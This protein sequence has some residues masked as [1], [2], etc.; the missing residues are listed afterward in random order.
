MWLTRV[1]IERPTLGFVLVALTLIAGFMALRNL[2][3]QEQPNSGLPAITVSA[4]YSGAS[5][6][7]LQTEIA[8]PIEDQLAGTPYLQNIQTTIQ[9]GQ[10]S[11][12]ATFSLQS[13]DTENI[14]NVE[15]A[16]QAAQK[17][18]PNTVI[19]TLRVADPSQPTIVTLAL[20]SK[21]Y[22]TG[23]LSA[24]ANNQIVPVI[25]QLPG[26]SNVNVAGTTQPAFMV[27]VNPGLL[28]ADNL[29]LT[30]V[31]NAITPN[32]LRAPG[33]YVYGPDRETELDVRGDLPDPQSVANL[34]I[35]V[36]YSGTTTSTSTTSTGGAG[37]GTSGSSG[38]GGSSGGG[39]NTVGAGSAGASSGTGTSSTGG[40]AQSSG[41]A[42]ASGGSTN[43]NPAVPRANATVLPL[44]IG[45]FVASTASTPPNATAPPGP[46]AGSYGTSTGGSGTTSAA[47]TSAGT[48]GGSSA[49]GSSGGSGGTATSGESASTTGKATTAQSS[50]GTG[51][52]SGASTSGATLGG[53]SG[54]SQSAGSPTSATSSQSTGSSTTNQSSSANVSVDQALAP[55][56]LT[57]TT[58]SSSGTAS[59]SAQPAGGSNPY[60]SGSGISSSPF[61]GALE[62]WAVPSADKRISDVATVLNTTV[63][64]RVIS[65]QNGR[66]GLTLLIQKQATASEVTVSN[67]VIAALPALERT[68][69]GVQFQV[70]HVQST[71]TEEQVESVEHTLV[72]GIVLTAIVML[73]FLGSWR[74]AVV[75][76]IAIPTSLGVTLFAM[77]MM[78]L[79]LDTISLMAMT[80]VIGILIDDS[81]VVLEN[82]QR[83]YDAGEAP[84]DAALNGRSEIGL[85]AIVITMVDVVVFLPIAF[86]GG[87]VGQNLHEFAIV[88][89]VATLTSLFV[90]FTI[91][92]MMAGLW[93]LESTW[94]PWR[95]IR[96][97]D[98]RFNNVRSR[99]AE[100]WL[101]AALGNPWPVLIA[102]VVLCVLAYLLVPTGLVGEEY[103]PAEDQGII[104]A[105]VTYPPGHPLS[106]T[107]AAMS[108][109]E[110]ATKAVI[111]PADL[112]YEVTIAGA[113]S[114]AFGGFVQE[115]N[116]GQVSIYLNQ[117]RKHSTYEDV[118]ALQQRY[119][120]VEPNALITVSA[121]TQQGGG[122]QQQIDELVSVAGGGDP[123]SYAAKIFSVLKATPGTA[124]AQ[125][126]ATNAAP[127]MEIE[128]NRPALQALDV[129][130]GTAS[131]AVEAAFGGNIAS[132]IET[133]V[134]GLTDIEV[135]YPESAQTSLADVLNIPI[136]S[137]NGGIVRLG[138]VAYLQYLPAP[139]IITR[140]NRQQV[141]HVTANVAPGY[142]LS[143]VVGTFQKRVTALHLPKT[144]TFRPAALGQQ[145]LLGQ[146][147]LAL[148]TSLA[149]SIVLV[150]LMIVAL[151][152][153][154]RT[155]F[156]TLFAIPVA[157]IGAIGALWITHNTLNLYSLIGIVLLVGL[158]T[159]NGILLV[160]YADTVRL[161]GKSKDEGIREAAA[162]RFRPIVMTTVAMVAGMLPLAL[163]LEPG[164]QTR[165]SLAIVVIGGLLSSLA[166]TLFIV[167]I[168][169][170]WIAPNQLRET[171]KFNQPRRSPQPA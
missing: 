80:L 138:D 7:D 92:P 124:G 15:R 14:A 57:S 122:N 13:T 24:L 76:M 67:E 62:N 47:G 6:T 69:P 110:A 18:L 61:V 167:P 8:Q 16:L 165:S 21:K 116:V 88:I 128:F 96:W 169:Y 151:Y 58:A 83:H 10:V 153:S 34:P 156:V 72:E 53:S 12:A 82:V 100:R 112:Q 70:A 30:D 99:Y 66:P 109:I 137:D 38:A 85:A 60:G 127:Q 23:A 166:L 32:N 154:Y 27:R 145:D 104:Y 102:A 171:T 43:T 36:S 78:G 170:R 105:Q 107:A 42:T 75:V 133:P 81:T 163:G 41:S 142:E 158:V 143:N 64:P 9:S 162:T 86:A 164:A 168:M 40:A 4:S 120:R 5:T 77:W 155:P 65:S 125:D 129:E 11:I 26:I 28:A 52:S 150:F 157:A 119:H 48:S 95:P 115:G 132:Q 91:T 94:R 46:A 19:P 63:V 140:Q 37:S 20:V 101:P 22:N 139:L 160:D 31:V 148:L 71:F 98:D 136:R 159:K 55:Q 93:S 117:D 54:Y 111:A 50:T 39:G 73:F 123:T 146:A 152:N 97:F 149:F 89:T 59:S 134:N 147:L 118:A 49:T 108:K 135:I 141:V 68:F 74:N 44:T 2:V 45:G 51:S 17:Q 114:A 35:H 87:Q 3:V 33:G 126:S 1:F 84:A 103:I 56:T 25:E 79:T 90:S 29:T 121:A 161:R 130:T 131:G 106:Q 113:Y 144:V